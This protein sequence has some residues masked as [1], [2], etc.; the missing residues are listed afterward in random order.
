MVKLVK[1]NDQYKLT[2][3]VDLVRDKGWTPG[4]EFR[5]VEDK[6]GNVTLRAIAPK[7]GNELHDKT[8]GGEKRA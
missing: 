7:H 4:T 1:N 8:H 3:P 6:E 5:F 2:I